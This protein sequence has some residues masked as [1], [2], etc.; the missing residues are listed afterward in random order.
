MG[1][2]AVLTCLWAKRLP[3]IPPKKEGHILKRILPW[4]M[5]HTSGLYSAQEITIRE[6][7]LLTFLKYS[8]LTMNS[9]LLT[10]SIWYV[11]ERY[12]L[13]LEIR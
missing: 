10:C 3:V 1:S 7:L 6:R 4:K 13:I 9:A 8:S 2:S 5:D 11:V 12:T